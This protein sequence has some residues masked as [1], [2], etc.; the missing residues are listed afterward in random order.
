MTQ[1]SIARQVIIVPDEEAA[2]LVRQA[3]SLAAVNLRRTADGQAVAVAGGGRIGVSPETIVG[4]YAIA[5][6]A[7]A[8][9]SRVEVIEPD[10]EPVA[11]VPE[12]EPDPES[13]LME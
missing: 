1:T 10:E 9:S 5:C 4:T 8:L 12:E 7:E 3:L 13:A 6:R 11:D 2:S